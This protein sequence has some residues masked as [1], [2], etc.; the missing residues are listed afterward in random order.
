MRPQIVVADLHKRSCAFDSK[1]NGKWRIKRGLKAEQANFTDWN[2]LLAD[3]TWDRPYFCW[4]FA[5]AT[6]DSGSYRSARRVKNAGNN[7]L[8]TVTKC[9]PVPA[10][11]SSRNSNLL[12]IRFPVVFVKITG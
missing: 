7:Q 10:G 11:K 2:G 1:K 6:R 9:S 5:K 8:T 12:N 4:P 3:Q